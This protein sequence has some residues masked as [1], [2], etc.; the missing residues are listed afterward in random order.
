MHNDELLTQK[1]RVTFHDQNE[2]AIVATVLADDECF[3]KKAR[4]IAAARRTERIV[5]AEGEAKS[6][7]PNKGAHRELI[8]QLLLVQA[9][10]PWRERGG[11][12]R[13]FLSNL[14][15][16]AVWSESPLEKFDARRCRE[17]WTTLVAGARRLANF[18]SGTCISLE[19][20]TRLGTDRFRRR[21]RPTHCSSCEAQKSTAV[22]KSEQSEMRE[23][24]DA[25]TGQRRR[26]RAARRAA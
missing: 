14:F 25:A 23:A 18:G 5:I 12:A 11:V 2:A 9:D 4:V 10:E 24:L 13:D 16:P 7:T 26:R 20:G 6:Y 1:E 15:R 17:R 3:Q 22:R 21:P 8:V 19:C